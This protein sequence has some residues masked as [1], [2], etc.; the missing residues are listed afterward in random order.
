MTT[1]E[2]IVRIKKALRQGRMMYDTGRTIGASK[3]AVWE[4]LEPSHRKQQGLLPLKNIIPNW[5]ELLPVK[6][7][8]KEARGNQ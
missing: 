5:K 2:Q 3:Y 6:V 7:D 8:I 1:K 4:P